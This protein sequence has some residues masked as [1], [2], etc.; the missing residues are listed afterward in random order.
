MFSFSSLFGN[1]SISQ[2]PPREIATKL[3]MQ[4]IISQGRPREIVL[5]T[6]LSDKLILYFTG[7]AIFLRA[8]PGRLAYLSFTAKER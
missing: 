3:L 4:S 8:V 7:Q 2:G 6:I 5:K 1:I